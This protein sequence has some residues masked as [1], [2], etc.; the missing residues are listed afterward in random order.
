MPAPSDWTIGKHTF[1]WE[2]PDLLWITFAGDNSLEEARE[3]VALYRS[4]G[5]RQPY[6]ILADTAGAGTLESEARRHLSENMRPEWFQGII[7]YNTRLV[8]RALARG[9][10][11]A[12]ELFHAAPRAS[13]MHERLHFTS[14]RLQ[15]LALVDQLRVSEEPRGIVR[16]SA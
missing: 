16:R 5:E 7:F 1:R 4:L 2:N 13:T 10:V 3:M 15:A 6:F 11:F 9:L 12:A 14:T 8:H